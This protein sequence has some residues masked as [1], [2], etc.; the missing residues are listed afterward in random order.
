MP[1]TTFHIEW[2]SQAAPVLLS[3]NPPGASAPLLLTLPGSL[4]LSLLPDSEQI[5]HPD[6]NCPGLQ[7]L[8][9]SPLLR[10]Q[11]LDLLWTEVTAASKISKT[12]GWLSH[13][14]RVSL[15]CFGHCLQLK[16]D[17]TTVLFYTVL[18]P[19]KTNLVWN[20]SAAWGLTKPSITL[21]IMPKNVFL[22][23]INVE[24]YL[25]ENK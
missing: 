6:S 17:Y 2:S 25:S 19:W 4:S 23:L 10:L 22:F 20:Q 1:C 9:P 24:K 13:C 7:P 18:S 11:L 12:D 8:L 15:K 3:A 5:F 14:S 16:E 21:K